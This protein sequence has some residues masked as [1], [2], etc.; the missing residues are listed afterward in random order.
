MKVLILFASLA[1]V[2]GKAEDVEK[3]T[4]ATSECPGGDFISSRQK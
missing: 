4:I 3:K 1:I 2:L